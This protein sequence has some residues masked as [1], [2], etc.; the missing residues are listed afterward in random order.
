MAYDIRAWLD[1]DGTPQLE[2]I[3]A[4]SGHLR[5]SWKAGEQQ[6]RAVKSLF[7]ELML[8]SLRDRLDPSNEAGAL[9]ALVD[10]Q[11]PLVGK[12]AR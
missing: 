11:R 7:H 1:P 5:V 8:L 3:D 12:P 10:R 4:D 2:I 6:S 9:R